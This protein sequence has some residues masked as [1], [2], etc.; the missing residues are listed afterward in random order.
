MK[1]NRSDQCSVCWHWQKLL[2]TM[3][4]FV[5]CVLFFSL[6]LSAR[7]MAQQ[8]RVT[9]NMKNVSFESLFNEIQRQTKLSFLFNHELVD[10]LGKVS[11]KAS[12]ET[13]EKVLNSLFDK[14][15]VTWTVQENM[16]VVK[17]K[18]VQTPQQAEMV[19]VYGKVLD[20]NGVPLP[21][22]TILLKGTTLGTSADVHG[23]Y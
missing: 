8:E 6:G 20:E 3:K 23:M 15:A 16:I 1:K 5:V 2:M 19:K 18:A 14:T 12:E 4:L 13:V 10:H 11:V 21:G 17:E 7:T 9:L 22:A